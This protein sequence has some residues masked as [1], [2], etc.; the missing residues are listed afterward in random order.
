MISSIRNIE[1]RYIHRVGIAKGWGGV[2][3]EMYLLNG[4]GVSYGGEENV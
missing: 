1:S 4:Y 3:N 2:G